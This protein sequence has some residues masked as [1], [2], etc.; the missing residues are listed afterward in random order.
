MPP[1]YGC[2]PGL[3]RKGTPAG[4]ATGVP[5]GLAAGALCVPDSYGMPNFTAR[6]RYAAAEQGE[7]DMQ[8]V[9]L[10]V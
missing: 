7:E 6:W 2:P 4:V 8:L 10:A 5:I 3:K 1:A 9:E